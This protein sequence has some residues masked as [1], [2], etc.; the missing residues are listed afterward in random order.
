MNQ[1][2][3]W[4]LLA[5]TALALLLMTPMSTRR[6]TAATTTFAGVM[7]QTAQ[8]ALDA[9]AEAADGNRNDQPEAAALALV[10]AGGTGVWLVRRRSSLPSS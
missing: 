1:S 2:V 9:L 10:L 8:S 5:G 7:V 4:S 6:G 3:H